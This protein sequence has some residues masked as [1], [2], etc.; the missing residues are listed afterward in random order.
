MSV[1]CCSENHDNTFRVIVIYIMFFPKYRTYT[2]KMLQSSRARAKNHTIICIRWF[3]TVL[4]TIQ[5]VLPRFNLYDNS[6]NWIKWGIRCSLVLL[7]YWYE[8]E[9]TYSCP[10]SLAWSI[11]YQYDRFLT[12]YLGNPIFFNNFQWFTRSTA[13]DASKKHK[14]SWVF[15]SYNCLVVPSGHISTYPYHVLV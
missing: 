1:F 9:P 8:K 4:P 6:K 12:M 13:L 3:L 7:H 11:A 14:S 10:I 5:P 15:F 2:K